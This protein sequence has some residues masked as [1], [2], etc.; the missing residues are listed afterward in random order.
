LCY[1]ESLDST[2]TLQLLRYEPENRSS[3]KI[4]TGEWL[5]KNKKLTT[6]LKYTTLTSAHIK[7]RKN[8]HELREIKPQTQHNQE[9]LTP[10]T[11]S[12]EKTVN[13]KV[14]K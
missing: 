10:L 4:T 5:L 13:L 14:F 2:E 7:Y 8:S 1:S 6:R 12:L 3:P 9:Y 11:A